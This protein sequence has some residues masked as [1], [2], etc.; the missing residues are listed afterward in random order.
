MQ[1][2]NLILE[3]TKI[4]T[5]TIVHISSNNSKYLSVYFP[6]YLDT[7]RIAIKN[8][9][10]YWDKPVWKKDINNFTGSMEDRYIEL[11]VKLLSKGY[12]ISIDRADLQEKIINKDFIK[13]QT[14]WIFRHTHNNCKFDGWFAFKW[15]RNDDFYSIVKRLKCT[16]YC[17]PSVVVPPEQYNLVLDF[18]EQHHFSLSE[19]AS[20]IIS[21][22]ENNKKQRI[23][24][25]FD[26]NQ[27]SIKNNEK[28]EKNTTYSILD[29]FK[30]ND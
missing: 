8:L 26:I 1:E 23:R 19:K 5:E 6:E 14:R 12:I 16:K 20:K 3:P 30:D 4:I 22:Q 21:E 27:N 7:F 2:N 11:C 17:S 13:E 18:S 9:G 24:V 28:I 25:E 29:E 15:S 10:Y